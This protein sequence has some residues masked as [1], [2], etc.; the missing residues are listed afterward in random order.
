MSRKLSDTIGKK[1]WDFYLWVY[2]Q[3]FWSTTGNKKW[4]SKARPKVEIDTVFETHLWHLVKIAKEMNRVLLKNA[5]F[6]WFKV[7]NLQ[8]SRK[9]SV[10]KY[11]IPKIAKLTCR[12][13]FI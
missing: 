6:K 7:Q 9:L 2:Y 12:E 5:K 3:S 1:E 10:V 13:N 8:K 4:T 11:A